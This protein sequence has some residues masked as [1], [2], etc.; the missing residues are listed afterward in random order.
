MTQT[1]PVS[2][3]QAADPSPRT[4]SDLLV[5]YLELFGVE[6]VFGVPGGHITRLYEA[7]AISEQRGG[8]SIDHHPP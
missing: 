3:P 2:S 1:A 5:D 8:T 4:M 7:L 6:H